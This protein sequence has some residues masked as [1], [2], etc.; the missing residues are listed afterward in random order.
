MKN[1]K[2]VAAVS[3]CLVAACMAVIF[4]LS[5]QTADES[6]ELSETVALFLRLGLSVDFIR[7]C[8]HFLEFMGLAVLVYNALYWS[9]GRFRPVLT[10]VITAAYAASDEFHQ[11][12]VDGR[13][14]QITDFLTDSF[15]ALLGIAAAWI[16]GLLCL[17][18][19]RRRFG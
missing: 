7:K 14:C 4:F 18:I 13:A 19:K 11:L 8:A 15:G 12:F 6:Q 1:K 3:W 5:A 17:K 10:F 9:F 2:A 16:I